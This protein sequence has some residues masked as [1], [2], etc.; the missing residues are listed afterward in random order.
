MRS[1][2]ALILVAAALAGGCDRQSPPTPQGN[3]TDSVVATNDDV[4]PPSPDEAT[5]TAAA[6]I[7]GKIDASHAGEL[8]PELAFTDPAGKPVR[9]DSYRDKPV[10]LNLWATWCAPCV[11]EMPTLDALARREAGKIQVIALSQDMDPAKVGTFWAK[12]GY[13]ALK[14]SLDPKIGFS[15]H[16]GVN[17]PTTILFDSTGREVWRVS[18]SMDWAGPEVAKALADVK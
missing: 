3:A 18:G 17:L 5:P 4:P 6:P 11:A 16:L 8:G 14:P 13:A 2:M 1:A 15:T 12:G 10:L 7:V 9:L